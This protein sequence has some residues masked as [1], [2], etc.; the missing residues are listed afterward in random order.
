[1][2]YNISKETISKIK[3]RRHKILEVVTRTHEEANKKTIQMVLEP[4]RL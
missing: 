2:D 4:K 1:M 3:K